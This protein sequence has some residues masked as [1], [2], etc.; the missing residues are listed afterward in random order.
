MTVAKILIGLMATSLTTTTY[1]ILPVWILTQA[2][3]SATNT[4][5]VWVFMLNGQ[6]IHFTLYPR[7]A[8]GADYAAA[9]LGMRLARYSRTFY[10]RAYH[11]INPVVGAITPKTMR[12]I[13]R[14]YTSR[15]THDYSLLISEYWHY[16]LRFRYSNLVINFVK[17]PHSVYIWCENVIVILGIW[18]SWI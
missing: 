14:I 9:G 18:K 12:L 17:N 4:T 16:C 2:T 10:A 3:K 6:T 8:P 5:V 13:F 7:Q 1:L 15:S 11:E